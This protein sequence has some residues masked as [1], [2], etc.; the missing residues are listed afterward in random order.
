MGGDQKT[1]QHRGYSSICYRP[2]HQQDKADKAFLRQ[3]EK[4]SQSQALVLLGRFN[5]SNIYWKVDMAGHKQSR[6]LEQL[7][8]SFLIKMINNVMRGGT[9]FRD[10]LGRILWLIALEG[11][12]A[13]E[14]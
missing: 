10:I 7:E 13:Q 9:L 11:K 1:D 12:G 2:S 6:F 5:H 4:A 14:G 8:D 3:V